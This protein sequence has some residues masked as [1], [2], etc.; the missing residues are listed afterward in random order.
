[1]NF[2]TEKLLAK[3]AG[4]NVENFANCVISDSVKT[5]IDFAFNQMFQGL[6]LLQWMQK[7]TLAD[8]WNA[9]FDNMYEFVFSL[10]EK[11]C[12]VDY[13]HNA[14][15]DFK[16]RTMKTLKISVHANEY[17]NCPMEKSDELKQ[18]ANEKIQSGIDIIK[19]LVSEPA[20]CMVEKIQTMENGQ[21]HKREPEYNR[22]R[23]RK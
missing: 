2:D 5:Q 16:K 7:I 22:E 8:A 13:L 23:S 1:M 19:K 4:E 21:N 15:F 18:S 9:A 20:K 12:V 17:L 14:I 11:N 3:I 10:S 6:S